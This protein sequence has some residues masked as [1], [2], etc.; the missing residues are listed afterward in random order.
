MFAG[1]P[2]VPG[3]LRLT[4]SSLESQAT[5][6]EWNRPSNIPQDVTVNYTVIV[7]SSD[8]EVTDGGLLSNQLRFSI[9]D[10]ERALSGAEDCELFAFHVVASAA[11]AE[12]SVAAVIMETI[13]I[14]EHA[15]TS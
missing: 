6:L 7:N 13:P 15:C 9:G 5:L 3:N 8:S 1:P 4:P 11:L 10:L 2:E 14:C 12:E